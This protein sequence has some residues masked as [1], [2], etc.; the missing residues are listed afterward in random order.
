[1]MTISTV[2]SHAD[3]NTFSWILSCF[4]ITNTE[5]GMVSCRDGHQ[6]LVAA[7]IRLQ[8]Q[9]MKDESRGTTQTCSA[10]NDERSL[11]GGC[12]CVVKV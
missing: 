8:P 11:R 2:Q 7:Y 9:N 4:K 12:S 10:R 3:T 6:L 5:V 1:M